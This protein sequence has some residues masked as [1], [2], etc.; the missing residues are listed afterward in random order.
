[1]ELHGSRPRAPS[2]VC[3][4]G[5]FYVEPILELSKGSTLSAPSSV[6]QIARTRF[7]IKMTT[8]GSLVMDLC[9]LDHHPASDCGKHLACKVSLPS[10]YL[11]V[12]MRDELFT[13][14]RRRQVMFRTFPVHRTR[15]CFMQLVHQVSS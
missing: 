13:F 5:A 15:W 8:F 9:A 7:Q 11:P 2:A 12:E 4:G 6:P 10:Y 1:M 3:F 14:F